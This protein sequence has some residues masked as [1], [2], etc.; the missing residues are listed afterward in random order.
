MHETLLGLPPIELGTPLETNLDRDTAE[1][2]LKH[3]NHP[4]IIEIK[5]LAKT[6]ESFTFPKTKTEDIK[7]IINLKLLDLMVYLLKSLKLLQ[8]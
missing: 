8:K 2:I 4:S 3:E 1:K 5:T 7:K 6:N